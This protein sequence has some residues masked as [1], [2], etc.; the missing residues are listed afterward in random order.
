MNLRTLFIAALLLHPS[1]LFAENVIEIYP[2]K[3]IRHEQVSQKSNLFFKVELNSIIDNNLSFAITQFDRQIIFEKPI[4]EKAEVVRDKDDQNDA[5]RRTVILGETITGDIEERENLLE[6]GPIVSEQ[7]EC[8][9]EI[10]ETNENGVL[11]DRQQ[12]IISLYDDLKHKE[13]ELVFSNPKHGSGTLKLTHMNVYNLFNVEFKNYKRSH[14]ESLAFAAAWDKDRF[15]P[16]QIAQLTLSVKSVAETEKS[17]D[18]FLVLG[19]SM[20]RWP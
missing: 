2:G 6:I 17:G 3:R 14:P 20:S 13:S 16:N 15:T 8:L 18:T 9:Q 4:Y 5:G 11:I 19:R 7:F 10:F 12:I 1:V